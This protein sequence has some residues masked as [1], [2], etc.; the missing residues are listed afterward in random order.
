MANSN[1]VEYPALL[2]EKRI[3]QNYMNRIINIR[4]YA[5]AGLQLVANQGQP[6]NI[7]ELQAYRLIIDEYLQEHGS[8]S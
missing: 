7:S 1:N 5:D 6:E 2:N 8:D 3:L 4:H